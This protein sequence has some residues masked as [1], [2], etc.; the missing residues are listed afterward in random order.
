[1]WTKGK[2]LLH[3]VPGNVTSVATK[4]VSMEDFQKNVKIT[5]MYKGWVFTQ[6]LQGHILSNISAIC[7][8]AKSWNQLMCASTEDWIK[9]TWYKFTMD[10]LSA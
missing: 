5:P 6:R 7:T 10:L 8:V 4:E 9:K 2:K 1:M 3:P